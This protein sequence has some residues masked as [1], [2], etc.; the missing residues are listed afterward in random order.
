MKRSALKWEASRTK[1]QNDITKYK[2]Q[3]NM[4][5]KLNRETRLQYFNNLEA[6]KNSKHFWVKVEVIFLTNMLMVM[7]R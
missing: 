6:S 7:L 4:V 3:Q 1:Q 5:V 2:K